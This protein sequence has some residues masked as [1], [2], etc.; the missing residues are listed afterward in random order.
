MLRER[1]QGSTLAEVGARHD[2]TAEG[3]RVIV[4]R[5][6]KR[7]IDELAARLRANRETGEVEAF[8]IPEHSGPDFDLALSYFQ[9]CVK[10]LAQ[11][12]VE[13]R[14]HYRPAHNGVVIGGVRAWRGRGSGAGH[15]R[16]RLLAVR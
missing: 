8:V 14:V 16:D 6:G 4:A 13:V 9:W 7:Q 1:L 11:R 15:P 12:G 10:Q 5:E 2:L 3:V